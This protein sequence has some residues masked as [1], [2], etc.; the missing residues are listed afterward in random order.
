MNKKRFT[1]LLSL[2]L[3]LVLALSLVGCSKDDGGDADKGGETPEVKDV[4]VNELT[5]VETEE[6]IKAARPL[7]V[8]IDNVGSAIPQSWLSKADMVY[9]FPVEASQTRLQSVFY[10]DMPSDFGP[11]RSTRPYFV[12]LAREYK[13]IFLAHGW[14]PEA[15][16]YLQSDVVPHI[17][18]MNSDCDFYRVSHKE[19]PHNSYLSFSE[20]ERKINENGWWDEKQEIRPFAFLGEDEVAEGAAA[21][22]I[23]VNYGAAN[24]EYTYD[25]DT[26]L[27]TRTIDGSA[28]VDGET[29][30]SIT[31]SNILVQ[32]VNSQVLDRKGRLSIDMCEG[33]AATLYTN[34]VAIEGTWTRASLDDRTIFTDSEGNE[35]KLAV[36]KTWVQIADQ[37]T[38]VSYQ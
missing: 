28:Y 11:I 19:S 34:G 25:A 22:Y 24:C 9:E 33:G 31:V 23:T 3:C 26:K 27:Y 15:K 29:N 10:G 7:V 16:Q 8:S 36:G 13:A 18:A 21:T 14:S 1:A 30:E 32:R 17:N 12:D 20:V 4:Y 35:F 37:N 5:G 38:S 6:P 2:L